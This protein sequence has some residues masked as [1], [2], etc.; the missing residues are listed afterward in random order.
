MEIF[1]NYMKL[2]KIQIRT[3]IATLGVLVLFGMYSTLFIVIKNKN[4]QISTLKNKVDFEIRK[5]QRLN[6]IKQLMLGLSI[7]LKQID[8][9]F[10]SKDGVV[11]FLGKL[12][13]LGSTSN[14]HISINSV[15]ISGDK[16]IGLPYELLKIEFSARG[17]WNSIVKLISLIETFPFGITIERMQLER[18]PNS[19]LWHMN[20]GFTVLK[21]K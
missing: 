5:D 17:S 20:I 1:N 10:I 3:I 11:Y 12:E 13:S 15:S 14:T 4:N 7:E 6:S 21:L 2:S 16:N 8:T 18:L 9:Y 19:S